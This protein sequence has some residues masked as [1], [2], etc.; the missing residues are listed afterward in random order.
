MV[1][2]FCVISDMT[3]VGNA[4]VIGVRDT[5]IFPRINSSP[6]CIAVHIKCVFPVSVVCIYG[7]IC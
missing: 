6:F 1:A 7:I 3:S 2:G 4:N 5:R